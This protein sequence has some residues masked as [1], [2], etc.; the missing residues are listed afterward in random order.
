MKNNSPMKYLLLFSFM[1]ASFGAMNG[2]TPYSEDGCLQLKVILKE[3]AK[4]LSEPNERSYERAIAERFTILY[5]FKGEGSRE[6]LSGDY[7]YV[8]KTPVV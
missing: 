2:Q 5:V 7:Y 4:I 8:G 3:N 1:I 6:G